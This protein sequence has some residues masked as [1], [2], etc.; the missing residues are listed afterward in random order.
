MQ[1]Y[2][3]L[4]FGN[5]EKPRSFYLRGLT[6]IWFEIPYPFSL[7]AISQSKE[8]FPGPNNNKVK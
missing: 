5:N 4:V 1:R 7:P 8:N 2:G 6:I 3:K